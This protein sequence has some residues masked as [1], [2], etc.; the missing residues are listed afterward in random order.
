[1]NKLTFKDSYYILSLDT[2]E[3][4]QIRYGKD[5]KR[6]IE[7][8]RRQYV[9][10]TAIMHLK[11]LTVICYNKKRCICALRDMKKKK[12]RV[13][14]KH[15]FSLKHHTRRLRKIINSSP[16]IYTY[17]VLSLRNKHVNKKKIFCDR[18]SKCQWHSK[19][20]WIEN[21]RKIHQEFVFCQWFSE[22][23][24]K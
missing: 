4:H 3:R 19:L 16:Y 5:Q 10:L 17:N 2:I 11:T 9:I 8:G 13:K 7:F 20:I 18:P 1:M 21:K 14:M 6:W 22:Q 23:L 24:L 15:I 12:E